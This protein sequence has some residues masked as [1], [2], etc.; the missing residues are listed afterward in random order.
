MVTPAINEDHM[1]LIIVHCVTQHEV[2]QT[3]VIAG[4]EGL[5]VNSYPKQLIDEG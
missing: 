2:I 4:R 5:L 1:C 3:C